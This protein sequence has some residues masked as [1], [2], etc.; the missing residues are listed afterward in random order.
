V[1]VCPKIGVSGA[2]C[3]FTSIPPWLVGPTPPPTHG[4]VSMRCRAPF[5]VAV[6]RSARMPRRFPSP[7]SAERI[8]GGYVVKDATGQALPFDS[9]RLT[10]LNRLRTKRPA[11][12]LADAQEELLA[13]CLR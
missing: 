7:W 8:P 12:T 10:Y 9:I 6:V 1:R 13:Q 2:H 3:F 5:Q 4:D 11:S